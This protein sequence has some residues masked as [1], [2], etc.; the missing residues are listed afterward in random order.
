MR[1]VVGVGFGP[2]FLVDSKADVTLFGGGIDVVRSPHNYLVGTWARL[3]L[4]GLAIAL[5]LTLIG[6][7]LAYRVV[8]RGQA[9]LSDA[10]VLAILLVVTVPLVAFVGVV[11]E[12]PFGA[13]PYFWALGHLGVLA[14]AGGFTTPSRRTE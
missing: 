6:W 9:R 10:D 7:R 5:A 12:S 14:R 2:N 1:D 8:S 3:G 4:I 13:I 11:L